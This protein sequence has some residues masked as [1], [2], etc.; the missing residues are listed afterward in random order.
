MGVKLAPQQRN[1]LTNTSDITSLL[2]ISVNM[3][4]IFTIM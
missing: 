2:L 4:N 1:R 3:S